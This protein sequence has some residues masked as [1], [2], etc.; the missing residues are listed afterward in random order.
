MLQKNIW[1][2]ALAL[3]LAAVVTTYGIFAGYKEKTTCM[4][5]EF[6]TQKEENQLADC[7]QKDYSSMLFHN[8]EVA[9]VDVNTRTVYISQHIDKNTTFNQ[10]EGA[11]K[12][13][14]PSAKLYFAQDK[15]FE[16]LADAVSQGHSFLLYICEKDNSY[17]QYNVVFTTLPV[18]KMNGQ[19]AYINQE[20][21]QVYSGD[22]C[23]WTA[24]D[25]QTDSYTVKTSL[26]E[27]NVRGDSQKAQPK[28]PYKLALKNKNGSNSDLNLAGLGEDDDWILNSMSFDDVRLRDKLVMDLWN[29]MCTDTPYN[30]KMDNGEYVEVVQNGE[31]IGLYLLQR[32]YDTKYLG[33]NDGVL[34]KGRKEFADPSNPQYYTLAGNSGNFEQAHAIMQQYDQ[35]QNFEYIDINNWIDVN[36]FINLGYMP[37]NIS[38][39][40]MYYML[41]NTDSDPS[42]KL[43]LWDTDMAFGLSWYID[44]YI[45]NPW[46]VD[47]SCIS[48]P[49]YEKLKELYP[50]L[51]AMQS[52][53]WQ[54]LRQDVLT[55][56]NILAKVENYRQQFSDSGAFAR[57]KTKWGSYHNGADTM[58]AFCDF[59]QRRLVF[60][61]EYYNN[62]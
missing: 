7:V 24:R 5:V 16:N 25:P 41:E 33:V 42:V 14:Y 46:M 61:D 11:L 26:L 58:E 19:E 40:N 49:E 17:S 20:N 56:Q 12:L 9:A 45:Y 1:R 8:G 2:L 50:Q 6:L 62:L 60:L 39:H 18:I 54:Q 27:W 51:D 57:D 43:I 28:K 4:G 10:L 52:Q 36:L 15:A 13:S 38:R 59:I 32:R 23:V 47:Q 29:E 37:D 22:I 3:F 30:Y 53:R 44:S 21:R 31:Y 34:L 48:R 55:Q 35:Q